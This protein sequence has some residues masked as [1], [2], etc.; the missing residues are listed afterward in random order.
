MKLSYRRFKGVGID[1]VKLS[2]ARDFLNRHR[3]TIKKKLLDKSEKFRL[4]PLQFAKLF[5]A[6]EAFFKA[7]GADW[8]GLE[9]FSQIR[10][11]P[12]K[13]N[14]FIASSEVQGSRLEGRGRFFRLPNHVGAEVIITYGEPRSAIRKKDSNALRSPKSAGR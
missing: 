7:R 12:L 10:V 4:T 3:E 5:A 9:G 8:M 13:G 11:A 1:I 2:R 14:R 6:K